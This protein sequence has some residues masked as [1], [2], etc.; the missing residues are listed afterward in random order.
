MVLPKREKHN[1]SLRPELNERA[2]EMPGKDLVFKII[3]VGLKT[4]IRQI[5]SVGLKQVS[6]F[7]VARRVD[8]T[9]ILHQ[10]QKAGAAEPGSIF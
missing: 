4:G 10:V 2:F 5:I 6:G 3:S 7:S 8:G 1:I 9:W